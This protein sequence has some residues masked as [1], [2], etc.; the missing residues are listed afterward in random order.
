MTVSDDPDLPAR[1]RVVA[2][3]FIAVGV[4]AIGES[5]LAM[6]EGT[7]A[8]DLGMLFPVVGYGL[9]RRKSLAHTCALGVAAW[10]YA[11]GIPV[12]ALIAGVMWR[13]GK[14]TVHVE[15]LGPDALWN[16]VGATEVT[17]VIV[18]TVAAL[19]TVCLAVWTI[20]MLRRDDIRRLFD[21]SPEDSSASAG[22]V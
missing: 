16:A 18:S 22:A 17:A 10:I 5:I 9:L 3:L 13:Q 20:R 4:Y 21:R 8:F 7:F 2:W 11:V 1:L 14:G 19:V 12:A 15:M 6:M